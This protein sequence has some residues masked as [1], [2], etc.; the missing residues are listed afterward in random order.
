MYQFSFILKADNDILMKTIKIF[1][2]VFSFQVQSV[3]NTNR[4]PDGQEK[5]YW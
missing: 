3:Y 5:L 2:I 4:M 1:I